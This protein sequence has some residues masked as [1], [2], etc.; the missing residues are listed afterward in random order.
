VP[1]AA[2]RIGGGAP[3][4]LG[5][6]KIALEQTLEEWI[7]ND[8]SLVDLGLL[9]V[10]RQMKVEGGRLD[11][12]CVDQQGRATI[13]EIKREKL[14]RETLAQGID[15]ASSIATLPIETLRAKVKEYLVDGSSEHPGLSALLD[16]EES[17]REVAVVVVGVGSEPGLERMIQFLGG[18]FDVPIRAITFDVFDLENGEKVLV[19]EETEAAIPPAAPSAGAGYTIE[20]VL[21]AAGGADSPA[22]R[23]MKTISD[24][25]AASGFYVRPYKLSLMITPPTKRTRYLANVWTLSDFGGASISYS[26]D[27]FAEFYPLSADEVRSVMGPDNAKIAIDADEEAAAWA[28]RFAALSSL[29]SARGTEESDGAAG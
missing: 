14:I 6:G 12:L 10:Q 28:Q 8:P 29:I 16:G 3:A 20:G 1:L 7:A 2:W 11:L 9:V 26:A 27:A 22:G 25:A 24:A 23:R 15:Y 19:R 17:E 4:R 18:K 21:S 5:A 13:V